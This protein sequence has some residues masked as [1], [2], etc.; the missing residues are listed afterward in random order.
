MKNKLILIIMLLLLVLLPV[1]SNVLKAQDESEQKSKIKPGQMTLLKLPDLRTFAA[2]TP[3]IAYA[4]E[5]LGATFTVGAINDG[6]TAVKGVVVELILKKQKGCTGTSCKNSKDFSKGVLLGGGS[7][8]VSLQPGEHTAVKLNGKNIIPKNTPAG[9]YFICSVIDPD[10]KYKENN[11]KNNCA[12]YP[13]KILSSPPVSEIKN[14]RITALEAKKE[15]AGTLALQWDFLPID[16]ETPT[17]LNI[18][19]LT[20]VDGK[21]MLLGDSIDKKQK[22]TA[23]IE[24]KKNTATEFKILFEATYAFPMKKKYTF[25]LKK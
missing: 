2:R 20:E 18:T 19:V 23:S 7:E 10:N 17:E 6:A 9:S 3:K 4:G 15:G 22:D 14:C 25:I 16:K 13:I 21:W 12:C 24:I 8:L 11:E 1:T 5:E